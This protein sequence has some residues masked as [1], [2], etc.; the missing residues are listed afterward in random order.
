M[1]LT[2]RDL[3]TQ[4][5]DRPI[6]AILILVGIVT[7]LRL[8]LLFFYDSVLGPDEA[9]YWFWGRELDWGYYSKPPMIG[10]AIALTTGLFGDHVWA[11]RFLSPLMIGGVA[12]ALFGVGRRLYGDRVGL[13][14]A[15]T[16][17]FLPAVMLGATMITTDVPLL[18]F[19]SFALFCLVMLA[20]AP[21]GSGKL[22]GLGL[23][24]ALGFGMLSKYAMIYFPLGWGL[25]LIFSPYARRTLKGGPILIALVVAAIIFAPNIWWNL[26]HGLQTLSHTAD[27]ADWSSEIGGFEE[28]FQFLGDQFG[29]AGPIL[30]AA[31]LFGLVTLPRRLKGGEGKDQF[32]LC[33]ILPPLLI[34]CTQAFLSRAHAN[35]AMAAYPAAAVLLPAWFL[36]MRASWVLWASLALHATVG[37]AFTIILT[38]LPLADSLGMSNSVKRLRGW[39]QQADDLAA[40][41]EGYDAVIADEREVAAHLVWEWRDRDV[42]LMVADING[43]HDNTYEYAFPF[44]PTREGRY[45]L[46]R[47]WEEGWC[48]YPRRFDNTAELEPSFVDLNATRRGRK[49]RTLDLYEITGWR[50]EPLPTCP[51]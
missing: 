11:V 26:Q 29:V 50:N 45:L 17:L 5:E 32:L 41:A 20:E 33:F 46:V 13:W 12:L 31:L 23:G 35:W 40:R 34:I 6:L 48:W 51:E 9:Q 36:R 42:P 10:W 47:P 8:V 3:R 19:W 25:A 37:L 43:R 18:L 16:W 4:I 38:H 39:E 22:S 24:A 49:E 2:F 44:E 14:A 30:F 28:L 1:P 15:V 7:F 21:K 27:N